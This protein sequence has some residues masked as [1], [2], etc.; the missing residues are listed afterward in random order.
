MLELGRPTHMFDLGKIQG[1]INVRWAKKG[2]S[3]K[4]LNEQT[5][6]LDEDV[7]IICAGDTIESLAGMMGGEATAVSLD[8][9]DVYVEAAFWY[10]EAIAGRARRYKFASEASHRFERGVDFNNVVEHLEYISALVL[11]LCGG[12]AGPVDDTVVNLPE[13]KPVSMRLARCQKILGVSVS[14]EQVANIFTQLGLPFVQEDNIFTVTPPSYRFDLEIE[15]DL[16]EE[17]ARIYGFENIPDVAPIVPAVMLPSNETQRS[18][19]DMRHALAAQ[20]RGRG[21]R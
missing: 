15:E 7:G 11:E 9:Q 13:R 4:L 8:T 21:A 19:H 16:I 17:V 14:A 3:L 20:G 6:E 2:E 5:V 12:Q 1:E 10:P 18:E